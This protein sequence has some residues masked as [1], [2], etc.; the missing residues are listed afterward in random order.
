MVRWLAVLL[1][2]VV[3][4]AAVAQQVLD[5]RNDLAFHAKTVNAFAARVYHDRLQRL[6]AAGSLDVDRVLLKRIRDL[7]TRLRPAAEYERPISAKIDW[8]AHVC[9]KCGENASAMAGGKLL[10][11]EEFIA[12]INP[13]DDELA[14]LLAHEM[15]HVLAEHTREFATT[16]RYFVGMGLKRDYQDIQHEID[17]SFSLQLRMAPLY[18]QQEMEADYI[19][20]ILGARAGFEPRAMLSLLRKLDS[21]DSS[22]LDAHPSTQQRLQQAQ[23]ALPAAQRLR[24]RGI[25]GR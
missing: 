10:V 18:K 16:A 13:S 25:P 1:F 7:V 11:G 20:F 15:G 4:A 19:G 23:A 22:M 14:Y 3:P 17:E 6:S 24:A 8:E 2:A 5:F 9:R 21:D 12:Q